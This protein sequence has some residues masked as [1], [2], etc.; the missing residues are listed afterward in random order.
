MGTF[1]HSQ[2]AG[3]VR[4]I[5]NFHMDGQ[6]WADIAYNFLVCPHGF[7]FEGRG[8]GRRSAANGTNA[9]N[10]AYHAVCYLGGKGDPFTD[11]AK[12]GFR[13]T[14]DEWERRY[15]RKANVHPHRYFLATECPGSEITNWISSGL[16]GG[17]APAPAPPQGV[18]PMYD[19][20]LGPIAA[21]WQDEG[22]RVLAA[23]SPDGH[24]FAWGVPWV[25]NMAGQSWWGS[26]KAARIGARDDGREGYM[27]TATSGEKYR[28]PH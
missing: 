19:P 3:K 20:P 11:A 8:W 22:G 25:G 16:G 5:Q 14:R 28:L 15:G 4:S 27:V 1:A 9:G 6:G 26:R 18:T 17:S 23:V 7:V 12:G 10:A 21:V 2:C 24:V 13:A